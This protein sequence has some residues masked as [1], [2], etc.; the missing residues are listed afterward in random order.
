LRHEVGQARAALLIEQAALRTKAAAKFF[1]AERLFFTARG[2]EQATDEQVARYKAQRFGDVLSVAD[3]C[4]GIGGDAMALAQDRPTTLVDRDEVSLVLAAANLERM[5]GLVGCAVASDVDVQGVA[6]VSAWH[7]DPD[8]RATGKRT[9]DVAWS[10]PGPD[11]IEALLAAVPN[12]SIKLAPAAELPS[13]WTDRCECEWI[14]SR[15]EC[16]QQVAWFGDLA[17]EIGRR[18]ATIIEPCGDASSFCGDPSVV[19]EVAE[20]A[21]AFLLDPSPS[22]AAAHLVGALAETLNLSTLGPRV[23]YLTADEPIV[24]PHLSAFAVVAELPLDV[25]KLKAYCRVHDIGQLEIKKRGVDITPE[26]LRPQLDLRGDR[27]ATL[28]L[29]RLTGGQRAFVCQRIA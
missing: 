17:S 12:G 18:V 20:Q 16:R 21:G 27:S 10:D 6:A 1:Q 25:R 3:L 14:E 29:A 2:L 24:H 19:A 8:R 22:L 23:A 13:E 5:D 28:I 7:I 4:C 15:G 9:S 26:K 11:V